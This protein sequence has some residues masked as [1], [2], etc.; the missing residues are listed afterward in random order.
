MFSTAIRLLVLYTAIWL[1]SDYGDQ[2]LAAIRTAVETIAGF[3][4]VGPLLSGLAAFAAL[5]CL[6]RVISGVL[7]AAPLPLDTATGRVGVALGA[8][9]LGD[10]LR[11]RRS[12]FLAA[13]LLEGLI[14]LLALR[15][16]PGSIDAAGISLPDWLAP[17]E[18]RQDWF[19]V[20][21]AH[22]LVLL[23][24]TLSWRLPH[25]IL[26]G[27]SREVGFVRCQIERRTTLAVF[28]RLVLF[29]HLPLAMYATGSLAH[30]LFL[31]LIGVSLITLLPGL[32]SASLAATVIE[33]R[34]DRWLAALEGAAARDPTGEAAVKRLRVLS[35][36]HPQRNAFPLPSREAQQAP[37]PTPAGDTLAPSAELGPA[38][39]PPV[40]APPRADGSILPATRWV[41]GLRHVALACGFVVL[42]TTLALAWQ[43]LTLPTVQETRR[44]A[45]SAHIHVR[46]MSSDQGLSVALLGNRYDYS[47]NTSLDNISPFFVNAIIASEDHRFF[48]HGVAYKVG[49]FLEAGL[50]C[51]V[52]KLN[53]LANSR[54]CRG[55][56]TIGQQLARNLFLSET[57]TIGRKLK[58]LL[59]ALKMETGLGKSEILELYLNRVYLG[60]GNFGVEMASRSYFQKPAKA[61]N[62]AEAAFLAAAVKRPGW[63]WHEDKAGALSRARLIVGLMRR[64]GFIDSGM[65]FP[66]RFSPHLGRRNLRKPYLGHLWQWLRP[67]VERILAAY[68]DGDYKVLTTLNAEVEVYA[69][70]HLEAE[71]RRLQRAGIAAGQG[72][73]VAMRPSGEVLAMVGGIGDSVVARGTNRAK[74]TVGLH[75]RPPA[76]AFKPVVYLAALEDGLRLDSLINAGPVSIPMANGEPYR[77]QNHDGKTYGRITMREGLVRS[78]N[79]AAVRLLYERVGFDGLLHT[80]RRLGIQTAD[81]EPLWGL[82]LGQGGVPLIELVAAYGVFA[83]GG[84]GVS[85][86]AAVSVTD[87]RGKTVWRRPRA[88]PERVFSRRAIDDLNVMLRDVVARGTARRAGRNLIVAPHLAGKTGTGDNFVDAWF[89]GYTADLV[90]GVWIGNDKPVAM[91]GVY[92][93]TAPAAAFNR[94][95]GDLLRF[96]DTVSIGGDLPL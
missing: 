71:L 5:L 12:R 58:E 53:V 2:P 11:L 22:L 90:I 16:L 65:A 84:Y 80:A 14:L 68:P 74:R 40:E 42:A 86:H 4:S 10:E 19:R 37:T 56:S 43:W 76:S 85:P 83:N 73:V 28:N 61:L 46:K 32:L 34:H 96:T 93:G 81:L 59:W 95:L 70:R 1:L 66:E 30:P 41:R 57:R 48:E 27:R 79:T 7:W 72:A 25:R 60:R 78:I 23:A 21:V 55:N 77:P 8:R 87:A 6:A 50:A 26:E 24:G 75:P 82:A 47:L 88:T 3:L 38:A 29:V 44:L 33:R 18:T 17:G 91:P 63:N 67:E 39:A 89:V 51:I 9:P 62:L 49:K 52:R 20:A 15:A 31:P 92:G 54:A 69:E 64:H 13:C 35:R 36:L 94:I 45:R